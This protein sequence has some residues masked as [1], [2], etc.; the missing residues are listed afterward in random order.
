MSLINVGKKD[1]TSFFSGVCMTIC[2]YYKQLGN[3]GIRVTYMIKVSYSDGD[4]NVF[5]YDFIDHVIS[6]KEDLAK[7]PEFEK[8]AERREKELKERAVELLEIMRQLRSMGY[9]AGEGAGE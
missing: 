5:L 9:K 4:I 1:I 3:D 8:E 2:K 7:I 6:S